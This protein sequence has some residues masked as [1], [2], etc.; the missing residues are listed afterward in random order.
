LGAVL[1]AIPQLVTT[2]KLGGSVYLLWLAGQIVRAGH[3]CRR[4]LPGAA[5]RGQ[6]TP[7]GRG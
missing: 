5:S 7:L 1:T 6:I 4:T 3:C 2:M